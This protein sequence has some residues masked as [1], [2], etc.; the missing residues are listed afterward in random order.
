MLSLFLDGDCLLLRGP[1]GSSQ[2]ARAP[3]LVDCSPRYH[4]NAFKQLVP[5]LLPADIPI[6]RILSL[7]RYEGWLNTGRCSAAD[8]G[9]LASCGHVLHQHTSVIHAVWHVQALANDNEH[10]QAS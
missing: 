3:I 1:V 9:P 7:A 8:Q 10:G 5:C 2:A 6:T 4:D